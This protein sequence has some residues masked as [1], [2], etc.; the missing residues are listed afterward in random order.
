MTT[1]Q[2]ITQHRR[3]GERLETAYG[4]R[5]Q[6]IAAELALRFEEGRDY[7]RALQYRWQ[8]GTNATRRHA[9]QEAIIHFAKA[10]DLLAFLPDARERKHLELGLRIVLGGSLVTAKGH[11]AP[12][13]EAVYAEAQTL[14][15]E[16]G[17]TP[18][19]FPALA[20]SIGITL[21][22]EPMTWGEH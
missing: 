4:T 21:S 9:H 13:V 19:L 3:V 15:R 14:C 20:G 22:E 17:D 12:E 8:A 1:R 5:V 18:Q 11:A 6:E 16:V 7:N 2:R 10:L